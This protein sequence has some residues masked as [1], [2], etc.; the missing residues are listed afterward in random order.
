MNRPSPLCPP[1]LLP[2]FR[3]PSTPSLLASRDC[4]SHIYIHIYTYTR[5]GAVLAK[6]CMFTVAR[7]QRIPGRHRSAAEM[8]SVR[9]PILSQCAC[10]LMNSWKC[11]FLLSFLDPSCHVSERQGCSASSVKP[12]FFLI[13]PNVQLFHPSHTCSSVNLFTPPG[14]VSHWAMHVSHVNMLALCSH[15]FSWLLK[16]FQYEHKALKTSH[17]FRSC[18]AIGL[19]CLKSWST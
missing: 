16:C 9:E 18:S 11:S 15:C 10:F 2:M 14:A 19:W 5:P 1:A 4:E 13:Q 6:L 17:I 12:V 3:L 7:F 8:L